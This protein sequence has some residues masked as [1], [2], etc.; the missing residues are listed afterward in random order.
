MRG[1]EGGGGGGG[2]FDFG[3]EFCFQTSHP[4]QYW[5]NS[6]GGDSGKYFN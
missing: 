1:G 4:I 5:S 6:P 2:A 3:K